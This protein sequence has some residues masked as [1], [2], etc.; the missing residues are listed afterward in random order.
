MVVDGGGT[1]GRGG[2]VGE[3]ADEAEGEDGGL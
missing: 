3:V 2:G 1:V